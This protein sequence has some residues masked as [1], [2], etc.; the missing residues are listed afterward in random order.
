MTPTIATAL[1][2]GVGVM[3]TK[4]PRLVWASLGT[5][6]TEGDKMGTLDCV[7]S[8]A[9]GNI[10]LWHPVPISACTPSPSKESTIRL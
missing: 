3:R 5:E 6:L 9:A 7:A 10:D 2:S 1:V 4:Y 8:W